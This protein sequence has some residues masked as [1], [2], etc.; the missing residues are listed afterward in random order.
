M[1]IGVCLRDGSFVRVFD[2]EFNIHC[3]TKTIF[4]PGNT[5]KWPRRG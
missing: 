3:R 4:V 1:T 2:I 5:S